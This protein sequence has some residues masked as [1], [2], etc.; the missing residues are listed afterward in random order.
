MAFA[1]LPGKSWQAI[2]ASDPSGTGGGR[3]VSP[4]QRQQQQR[5]FLAAT[6]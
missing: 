5:A 1:A 4:E 3:A 2:D 6:R